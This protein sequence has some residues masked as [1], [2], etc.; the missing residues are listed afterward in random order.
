MKV[1]ENSPFFASFYLSFCNFRYSFHI[2]KL[3]SST[4]FG[5]DALVDIIVNA[6][7]WFWG[8]GG[9]KLWEGS[10]DLVKALYTEVKNGNLSF[11]GKRVLEVGS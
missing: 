3:N 11:R 9:L 1:C 2:P 7:A 5:Y 4:C 6:C 8:A 10:L